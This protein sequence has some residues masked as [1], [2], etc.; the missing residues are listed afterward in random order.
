MRYA[1]ML[2]CL[3]LAFSIA[4][5][6]DDPNAGLDG[7]IAP[8]P[9]G[10]DLYNGRQ[11]ADQ[12]SVMTWNIYVGTDVDK[13]MEAATPDTIP[14]LVEEVFQGLLATDFAAR[15]REIAREIKR[16]RPHLIGLQEVTLVRSQSP[17]DIL[18]AGNFVPNAEDV[19]VDFLAILHEALAEMGLDYVTAAK[20][21]DADVEVPRANGIPPD[22]VRLTDFDVVLARGD[23]EIVDVFEKNYGTILEFPMGGALPVQ[24]FRGYA[25]VDAVVAGDTYRFV[26]THLEPR[27]PIEAIQIAQG[28]ELI[29][30]MAAVSWPVIVVGDLNSNSDFS[31]TPTYGNFLDA[32]YHDVWTEDQGSTPFGATCCQDKDLLNPVSVLDRRIDYILYRPGAGDP[33]PL[34][35]PVQARVI[36]EEQRNRTPSGLWPSDHAGVA[37]RF[38]LP[39]LPNR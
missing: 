27:H 23:V 39:A 33:R 21:Q 15:A 16:E 35:G 9:T 2:T 5:C 17:G 31:S 3:F 14:F 12:L 25:S 26:S 10:P 29:A 30:D 19:V 24:I 4:A 34:S 18:T 20:I 6:T 1:A 37:A 11:R 28:A 22:D 13:V 32:G 7:A 38:L 36:G 8:K